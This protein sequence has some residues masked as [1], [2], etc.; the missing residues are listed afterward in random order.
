MKL[1]ATHQAWADLLEE[2][3]GGVV[4]IKEY[5]NAKGDAGIPIFTSTTESGIFAATIGLMETI[6]TLP[7]AAPMYTELMIERAAHDRTIC[8]LLASAAFYVMKEGF[9]VHP[10]VVFGKLVA[11]FYPKTELPHLFFTVPYQGDGLDV[12]EL[13]GRT[14]HPLLGIPISEAEAQLARDARGEKLELAWEAK[15]T[16]VLD[17][18]LASVV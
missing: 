15:A 17:W 12:A 8:N 10:G 11:N 3:L 4:E 1:S 5:R 2:R 9:R 16:D 6:Q 7:P 14:I 13:P 18:H